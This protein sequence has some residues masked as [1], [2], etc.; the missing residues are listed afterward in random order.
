MDK[1]CGNSFKEALERQYGAS[2]GKVLD[3]A[4][5]LKYP[6]SDMLRIIALHVKYTADPLVDIEAF[7]SDGYRLGVKNIMA[8]L[9]SI[10]EQMIK[11]E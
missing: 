7:A 8:E 6:L 1:P 2:S 3:D 4:I 5:G 10:K 11:G 9:K